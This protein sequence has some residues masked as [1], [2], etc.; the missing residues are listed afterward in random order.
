MLLVRSRIRSQMI[1]KVY[2]VMM[3]IKVDIVRV[4]V[5]DLDKI[6]EWV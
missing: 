4:Y 1:G 3:I 2:Q 5:N 6:K